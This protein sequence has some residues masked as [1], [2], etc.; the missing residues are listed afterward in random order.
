MA[1]GKYQEWLTDDGLLRIEGWARDGLTDKQIARNMGVSE[2]T[3]NVWKKKYPSLFES[4]KRGKEVI[5]REVENALLKRA[6][7]YTYDEVTQEANEI[8]ELSVTKVVTKQVVPDTTA[9]IFWL[10]NRKGAEWS[11]K[12]QVDATN[13]RANTELTKAK[14]QLIK[15]AEHDTSLMQVLLDVLS[16]GDAP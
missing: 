3:L 6:L 15:G 14:T 8:G 11:N 12:D 4:L 9:Q 13:V 10:R 2:Q 7:G 16:G 1:S 5:D